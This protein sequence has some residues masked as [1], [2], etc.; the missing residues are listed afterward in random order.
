MNTTFDRNQLTEDYIQ[1]II[2]GMDNKTMERFVYDT[3]KE[4]LELYSDEELITEVNE[5]FSEEENDD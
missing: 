3:M 4:N 5:Y 2:E 1:Q